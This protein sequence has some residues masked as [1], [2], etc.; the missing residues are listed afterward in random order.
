MGS[1][2]LIFDVVVW[3]Y[4][5]LSHLHFHFTGVIHAKEWSSSDIQPAL[6]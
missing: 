5:G 3:A 6:V 4:P 2:R 1:W